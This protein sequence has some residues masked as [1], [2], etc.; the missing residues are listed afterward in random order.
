MMAAF[1]SKDDVV[2]GP[3]VRE[4]SHLAVINL[5]A[6][7]TQANHLDSVS[8]GQ[9]PVMGSLKHLKLPESKCQHHE[10]CRN[11]VTDD[12]DAR[13]QQ[14][15]FITWRHASPGREYQT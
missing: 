5:A 2:R 10:N 6:G 12:A 13:A 14:I 9:V 7:R 11:N 1:A 3:V 15:Q 8:L 4:N